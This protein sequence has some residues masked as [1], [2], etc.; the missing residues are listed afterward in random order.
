MT[1]PPTAMAAPDSSQGMSILAIT[2]W[3]SL[4]PVPPPV[5]SK[6]NGRQSGDYGVCPGGV[7]WYVYRVEKDLDCNDA[8]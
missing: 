3:V 8:N 4:T 5:K 1:H 2:R 6:S 7:E